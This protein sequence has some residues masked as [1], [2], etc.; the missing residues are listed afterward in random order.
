MELKYKRTITILPS[1]LDPEGGLGMANAFDLFMDT[2]TLAAGAMGVGW[3]F[4][5]KK[6]LF[7]ITVKA[8]VK[9]LKAPRLMDA[10]E[11]ATWPERPDEKRCN[12]HY[13]LRRDGELLAVGKTEWAIVNMLTHRPQDMEKLL[14][15]GLDYPGESASPEPF[16]RVDERFDEPPYHEHRV[17]ALDIDMARHM[18]NVAYV[19]AVVNSFPVREWKKLNVV[20][21]DMIFLS[22]AVE[23]DVLT[24]QKRE[25][26]GVI[27]IRGAIDGKRTSFL[28]RL[29]RG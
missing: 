24:L 18:N 22:S 19:R 26:R 12:R 14:P 17:G 1:Q 16:P 13:T 6:G 4:L 3:D 28:A 11:V 10:V 2:A 7:W 9:F 8:R 29:T 21:M 20:Q 5:K 25:S 27:D 15:Q 23:G